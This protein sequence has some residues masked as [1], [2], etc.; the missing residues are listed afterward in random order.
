M[1]VVQVLNWNN[2]SKNQQDFP[3]PYA[4]VKLEKKLCGVIGY[5]LKKQNRGILK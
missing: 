2:T 4:I 1:E 5:L 3:Q